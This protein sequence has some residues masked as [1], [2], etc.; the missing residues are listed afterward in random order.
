MTPAGKIG[1]LRD[2][3][4][5]VAVSSGGTFSGERARQPDFLTPY[6]KIV[7]G[8]IGLKDLSFFTVEG[9]GYGAEAV[10]R[11]RAE[12]ERVVQEHFFSFSMHANS[13]MELIRERKV[14]A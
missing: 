5:F 6:L 13:Q 7:L 11:A 1:L 9:T 12:S 3:P 4:V 14:V 2:R 8:T 10:A